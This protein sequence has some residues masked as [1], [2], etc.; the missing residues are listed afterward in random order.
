M[1]TRNSQRLPLLALILAIVATG[2]LVADTGVTPPPLDLDFQEP[3][4][5]SCPTCEGSFTTS[6]GSNQP[7]HWGHGT[8]CSAAKVD[9]EQKTRNAAYLDCQNRGYDTHCNIQVIELAC[10]FDSGVWVSDGYADYGCI[11]AQPFC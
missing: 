6:P 4:P 1:K 5:M 9:L 2:P 3:I 7:S 10:Y 8:S 11:E